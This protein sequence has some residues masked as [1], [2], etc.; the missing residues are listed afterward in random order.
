MS[1][2]VNG[3]LPMTGSSEQSSVHI[4][5][6][7]TTSYRVVLRARAG[8]AKPRDREPKAGKRRDYRCT[9]G[10]CGT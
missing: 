7:K 5:S 10:V 1:S 6:V 9:D 4:P 2:R 8:K 3:R